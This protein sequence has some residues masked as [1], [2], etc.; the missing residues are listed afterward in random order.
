MPTVIFDFDSTLLSCESLEEMIRSQDVEASTMQQI[1]EITNQGM[2]GKISFLSSLEKRLSLVPLKKQNVETFGNN[3]T[4]LLTPGMADLISELQANGVEIWIVSG[5]LRDILLP[6]G[7]ML[8]IPRERL[9]G[10]TLRWNPHGT[11]TGIDTTLPINRSKWEG[12]KEAAALWSSPKIAVGDGMTDY[13]L[14]EHGLVDHFIAFTQIAKRQA[15]LDKKV[16]EAKNTREL[17]ELL[18]T[19]YLIP[20]TR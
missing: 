5:A 16:P 9:L 10:I 15:L 11:Y 6:V 12:A 17:K 8:K 4:E 2:A 7:K 3:V 14:W 20:K 18:W 13:A 1:K 19:N